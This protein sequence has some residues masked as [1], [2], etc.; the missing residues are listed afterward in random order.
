M[1]VVLMGPPG[2]G[3]S[4]LTNYIVRCYGFAAVST[5]RICREEHPEGSAIGKLIAPCRVFSDKAELVPDE[6]FLPVWDEYATQLKHKD[7]V[8]LDGF[9]RSPAQAEHFINKIDLLGR[10]R[11]VYL[12]Q[13]EVSEQTCLSRMVQRGRPD[14]KLSEHRELRITQYFAHTIPAIKLLRECP[15]IISLKR[16]VGEHPSHITQKESMG[17]VARRSCALLGLPARPT[18][19]VPP[20]LLNATK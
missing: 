2:A 1:I 16:V 11:L 9:P 12:L 14:D 18:A 4:E 17:M 19:L 13:L 10:G 5:G 6:L 7:K 20:A 3:K 15:K 8:I